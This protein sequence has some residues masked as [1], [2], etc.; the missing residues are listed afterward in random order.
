[1]NTGKV[2]RIQE[3]DEV[4]TYQEKKFSIVELEVNGETVVWAKWENTPMPVVNDFIEYENNGNDK[5]GRPKIKGVKI[6]SVKLME[7]TGATSA[8]EAKQVFINRSVALEH[9]VKFVDM[10]KNK[11]EVGNQYYDGDH[12]HRVLH[13][14]NLFFGFLYRGDVPVYTAP[15]VS[16]TPQSDAAEEKKPAPRRKSAE[17]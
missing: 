10:T 12:A 17:K 1:M 5:Q 8:E 7:A 14:A 2:T 9:A 16:E 15:E 11:S 4:F 3:T 13:V 6:Q